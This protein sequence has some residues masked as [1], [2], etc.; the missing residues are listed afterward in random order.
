MLLFIF[1]KKAEAGF[2]LGEAGKMSPEFF[3]EKIFNT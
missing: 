1:I 2:F 3:L